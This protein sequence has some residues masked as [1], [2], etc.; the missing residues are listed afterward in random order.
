MSFVAPVI[1]S[2]HQSYSTYHR[3]R[4]PIAKPL[5]HWSRRPAVEFH[6]RV[7]IG[8]RPVQS[9][10]SACHESAAASKTTS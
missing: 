6:D 7:V 1:K 3:A 2:C 9:A 10:C 5:F 8:T 4:V